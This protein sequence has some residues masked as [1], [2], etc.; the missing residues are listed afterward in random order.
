MAAAA[1]QAAAGS[2]ISKVMM[3]KRTGGG[4]ATDVSFSI[5]NQIANDMQ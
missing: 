2:Q 1:A 5:E 3:I 4:P